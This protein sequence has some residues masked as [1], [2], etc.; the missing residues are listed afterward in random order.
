VVALLRAYVRAG[1]RDAGEDASIDVYLGA[2]VTLF[3]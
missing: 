3:E 2:P 1:V